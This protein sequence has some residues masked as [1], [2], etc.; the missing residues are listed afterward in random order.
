MAER[1]RKPAPKALE[2]RLSEKVWEPGVMVKNDVCVANKR[3]V[4][5]PKRFRSKAFCAVSLPPDQIVDRRR[6]GFCFP[7]SPD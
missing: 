1:G 3:F 7:A 2:L 5:F 6:I 4:L